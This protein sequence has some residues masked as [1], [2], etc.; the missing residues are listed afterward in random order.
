MGER[1]EQPIQDAIIRRSGKDEKILDRAEVAAVSI[2]EGSA[3]S[4]GAG[5]LCLNEVSGS[6]AFETIL[7]DSMGRQLLETHFHIC[8]K[9][10]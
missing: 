8:Q 6:V 7:I 4:L 2:F 9:A 1:K 10:T 3:F 5:R